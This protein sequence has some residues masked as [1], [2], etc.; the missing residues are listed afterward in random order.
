MGTVLILDD[1]LGFVFWLGHLLDAA[2]YS[3]LPAKRVPDGAL[4][5][6]QLDLIVDVLVINLAL[7]GGL[8]FVAALRRS[9]RDSKVIGVLN[10][11][12]EVGN[13]PGVS[14]VQLKP[15]IWNEVARIEWLQCIKRVLPMAQHAGG[16]SAN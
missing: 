8:D 12:A 5:V 9:Q 15:S 13:I 6:M 10:D 4:L 11:P 14:A 7:A 16:G 2:G 3:T 1:D